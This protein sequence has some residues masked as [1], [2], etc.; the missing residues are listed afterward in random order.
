MGHTQRASIF[1]IGRSA[2][3][4]FAPYTHD[5]RGAMAISGMGPSSNPLQISELLDHTMRFLHATHDLRAC[6]QIVRSWVHPAQSRIFSKIEF[7][8]RSRHMTDNRRS[9]LRFSRLLAILE[10]SPH[11]VGFISTLEITAVSLQSEYLVRLS[12]LPYKV[13]ASFHFG[14]DL[15]VSTQAAVAIH[16]LLRAPSLVWVTIHCSFETP[17]NFQ[18]WEGCSR[19]IR[20]LAAWGHLS[21]QPAQETRKRDTSKRIK[22]A[23]L[24]F[25]ARNI[26]WWLED[27]RCPFDASGLTAFEVNFATNIFE[28]VPP[29]A[30]ETIE[31]MSIL[32]IT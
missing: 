7:D 25:Q 13:L 4:D 3:I 30:F 32:L 12:E 5:T 9:R 23:A 27:P 16:R 14:S 6:A 29:S 28:S 11:L 22:L 18:I 21:N 17:E 8:L 10:D 15:P 31:L 26:R 19:N 20:H 24:N 1:G 2:P